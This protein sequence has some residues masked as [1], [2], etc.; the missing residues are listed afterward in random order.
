MA[1]IPNQLAL[2]VGGPISLYG[3]PESQVAIWSYTNTV[4][5]LATVLGA[6]YISDGQKRGLTL[7]SLVCFFDGTNTAIL[8]VSALQSPTVAAAFAASPPTQ[9]PGGV[10]L[11]A[12]GT[13]AFSTGIAA[14]YTTA[15]LQSATIPAANVI[16]AD[17][18]IFDN[19]GTTPANLQ[20]PT[21]AAL[22]AALPDAVVG[23][24][25][26][27]IVKNSSSGA[28]TLTLTTN[29]G[30]TLTGTMTAI[31]NQGRMLIVT[32]TAIGVAPAVTF[33]SFGVTGTGAD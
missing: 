11:S 19:T 31:Q 10:T 24:S 32:F 22:L 15:A 3:S 8:Q 28:N 18:V 16:G 13:S 14:Q 7:G 20:L 5:A 4:D 6:N 12:V 2:I 29:T 33:Q 30:L 21:A 27:L 1:Y 23:L 9:S 25:Y 26:E 17:K